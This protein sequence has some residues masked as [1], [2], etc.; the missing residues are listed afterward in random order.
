MKFGSRMETED[1]TRQGNETVQG[2]QMINE[3][4]SILDGNQSPRHLPKKP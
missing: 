1:L 3:S 4:Q 2:V